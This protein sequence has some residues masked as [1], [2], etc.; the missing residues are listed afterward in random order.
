MNHSYEYRARKALHK[1][2]G[3]NYVDRNVK[4]EQI[5]KLWGFLGGIG[6]SPYQLAEQVNK[7]PVSKALLQ[8]IYN[9]LNIYDK[10]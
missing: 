9:R 8:Q 5:S 6:L 1:E 10:A 3:S 7:G 4:P 2:F